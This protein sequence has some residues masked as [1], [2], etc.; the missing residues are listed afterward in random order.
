MINIH[1]NLKADSVAQ[2]IAQ[3]EELRKHFGNDTQTVIHAPTM[4][5]GGVSSG[6]RV[7]DIIARSKARLVELNLTRAPKAT[8][9]EMELRATHDKTGDKVEWSIDLLKREQIMRDGYSYDIYA[10][11]KGNKGDDDAP[12]ATFEGGIEPGF[13]PED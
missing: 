13:I 1:I 11:N 6:V 7:Q 12:G 8:A 5:Q 2:A 10:N 3:V 4:A 9:K